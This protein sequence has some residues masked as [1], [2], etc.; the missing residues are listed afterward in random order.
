MKLARMS[1]IALSVLA[2]S[3]IPLCAQDAPPAAQPASSSLAQVSFSF[4]RKG[5]PVPTYRFIVNQDATGAYQG[6]EIPRSSG[7]VASAELP[8]QSFRSPISLS[9]ATTARIFSLAR[10]L[11]HFNIPCASKAKNIADTGTKT[12]AYAGPDGAGSCTYNYTEYKDV[13]ALTDLFQGIAETLDEGRELDR[14][15]RYDRLGLDAAMTFLAQ[16]VLAGHAL[17]V[18]TIAESLRS[19]TADPDVME[20][21]RTRAG[22]LLAQIPPANGPPR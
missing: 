18:G 3:F 12:L 8:P 11:K 15:H 19:I 21:V 5:V 2:A 22:A 16:E 13:Q 9:P 1:C 14:L 20:R 7:P 17:E 4:D 10:Q 6:Q